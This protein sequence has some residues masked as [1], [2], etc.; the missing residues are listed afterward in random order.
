M[1]NEKRE[2]NF[3][4]KKIKGLPPFLFTWLQKNVK[5]PGTL[6]FI[7]GNV[8]KADGKN[9]IL[10]QKKEYTVKNIYILLFLNKSNKNKI[11]A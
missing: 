5:A 2:I 10:I 1:F 3:R 6:F 4:E 11:L 8:F 7:A 9:I